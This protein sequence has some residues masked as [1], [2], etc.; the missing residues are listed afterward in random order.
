[1]LTLGIDRQL[2]LS[3]LF[4]APMRERGRGGII[5]LGSLAGFV[6]AEHMSLYAAAKAVSRVFADELWLE[7]AEHGVDVTEL[8]LGVPRSPA[9]DRAG[10]DL[11][12]RDSIRRTWFPRGQSVRA[13]SHEARP[14]MMG[15]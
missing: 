13:N 5:L 7:M 4:G 1:M 8:V 6:G 15:R 11:D 10:L 12:M 2:E 14:M 9:V 3:Q